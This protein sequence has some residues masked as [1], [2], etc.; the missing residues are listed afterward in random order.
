MPTFK[1]LTKQFDH[2]LRSIIEVYDFKNVS[3]KM[4]LL[5]EKIFVGYFF[6]Y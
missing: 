2:D 4:V 3:H 5:N 6:I 1:C